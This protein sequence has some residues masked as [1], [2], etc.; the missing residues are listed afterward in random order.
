MYSPRELEVETETANHDIIFTTLLSLGI[1]MP[2]IQVNLR[3]EVFTYNSIPTT[4]TRTRHI[5]KGRLG[6]SSNPK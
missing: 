4:T 2:K 1:Q 6:L 3:H 5:D